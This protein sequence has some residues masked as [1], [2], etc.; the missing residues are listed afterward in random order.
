M[1]KRRKEKRKSSRKTLGA[2]SKTRMMWAIKP[3]TQVVQNGKKK[4]EKN[5]KK[6]KEK[7][8]RGDYQDF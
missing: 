7:L 2:M 5:R 4:Q 6:V 3:Q 8:K 1:S